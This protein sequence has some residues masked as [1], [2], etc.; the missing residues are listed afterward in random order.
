MT[1]LLSVM[2]VESKKTWEKDYNSNDSSTVTERG[3][4]SDG[5]GVV[6]EGRLLVKCVSIDK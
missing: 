6:R 1:R 3:G 5:G 2:V 4:G